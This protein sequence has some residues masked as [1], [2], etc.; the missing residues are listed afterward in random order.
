M[1]PWLSVP[2]LSRHLNGLTEQWQRACPKFCQ[3]RSAAALE[4]WMNHL[5]LPSVFADLSAVM[6]FVNNFRQ[7]LI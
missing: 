3:R 2:R 6:Y 7:V 4:P 5:N 1:A